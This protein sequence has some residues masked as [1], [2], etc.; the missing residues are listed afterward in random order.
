MSDDVPALTGTAFADVLTKIEFSAAGF[1]GTALGVVLSRILRSRADQA[2][3][4]FIEEVRQTTRAI[5]DAAEADE[6]VA[7][8][9]RYLQAACEGA[10]RLNLRLMAK[11]VRGQIKARGAHSIS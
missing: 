11:V 5:R 6:F 8:T 4:I 7:I 2:R 10:A 3:Q 9:Y 1:A